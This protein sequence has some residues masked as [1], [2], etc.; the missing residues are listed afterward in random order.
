MTRSVIIQPQN[1]EKYRIIEE[2]VQHL[3]REN[4]GLAHQLRTNESVI[5]EKV[6]KILVLENELNKNR[7][8]IEEMNVKVSQAP[9]QV[10][11][12]KDYSTDVKKIREFLVSCNP[13]NF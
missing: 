12:S 5:N 1:D 6:Q 10:K 13:G 3:V 11:K 2:R 8:A 4:E 9:V 7:S